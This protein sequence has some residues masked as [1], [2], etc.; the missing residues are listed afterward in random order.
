MAHTLTSSG[1]GTR[2]LLLI[3]S[4]AVVLGC[5][6]RL[7]KLGK[8]SFW[9]DELFTL[10]MAIHHPLWPSQE[11]PFF[12]RKQI[13]T[14][15]EG[16]T[17]LTAKAAEQ[18]PPL[19]DLAE[20]ISVSIFG[21]HEWS[22]RLPAA[23]S[24]CLLVIWL[25]W[26][27]LRQQ[28]PLLRR[29]LAW[30]T[31]LT[32][33]SPVLVYYAKDGRAYSMGASWV[34]MAAVLW[35][36]RWYRGQSEWRPPSWGE[37]LLW[38]LACYSHYNAAI[39]AGLLLA[40]DAVQAVRT[41]SFLA[42]SRL[43]TV[44]A[45]LAVWL[46]FNFHTIV[47]TSKGGVAWQQSG[48]EPLA[49]KALHG[50]SFL[51]EPRWL[52]LGSMVLMLTLISSRW[53]SSAPAAMMRL[54]STP[55]TARLQV[56]PAWAW[57]C[58]LALIYALMAAWVVTKAGMSHPRYYIFGLPLVL[59]ALSLVLAGIQK[60]IWQVPAALALLLASVPSHEYYRKHP[61]EDFRGITRIALERVK[62]DSA[63]L[64]PWEPNLR[65]Y[66][67][68]ME[69]MAG[70]GITSRM[71]GIS[72]P[73]QVPAVCAQLRQH[74]HVAVVAHDSGRKLIDEVYHYCQ[75]DWPRREHFQLQNTYAE[76]WHRD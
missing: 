12:E 43:L 9:A 47:F 5:F 49:W 16:D 52:A 26:I 8:R 30:M 69:L 4:V 35:G 37:S 36:L 28:D 31:W 20:K 29:A 10:S 59:M 25:A 60:R 15:S 44:G 14:L 51:A 18:S 42:W 23:L 55:S 64:Y 17:F 54:A 66:R 72:E 34:A 75:Q 24:A 39:V 19:N 13:F 73:G 32:V 6:L 67:I 1:R 68:Y 65:M 56:W 57:L 74:P 38:I 70:P 2:A 3:L 63:I 40:L 22:A 48:A 58:S 7:D 41:R 46:Y 76:H 33:L 45:A 71:I 53:R 61:I 62:E 21:V 50:L 27:S 11:K